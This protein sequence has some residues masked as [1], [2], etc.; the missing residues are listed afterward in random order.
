MTLDTTWGT[1][2]LPSTIPAGNSYL[3]QNAPAG[4]INLMLMRS[5]VPDKAIAWGHLASGTTDTFYLDDSYFL[6]GSHGALRIDNNTTSSINYVRWRDAGTQTWSA[7]VLGSSTSISAGGK[8]L[9][10][11]IPATYDFQV[12]SSAGDTTNIYNQVITDEK[13][14]I[15]NVIGYN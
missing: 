4:Y 12:E 7:D 13:L 6:S 1:S 15:W 5:G 14:I 10:K 11:W 2:W 3:F 9:F 8:Y